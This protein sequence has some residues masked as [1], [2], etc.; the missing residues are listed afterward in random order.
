LNY[1]LNFSTNFLCMQSLYDPLLPGIEG[2]VFMDW[3]FSSLII[4]TRHLVS[5]EVFGSVIPM[6]LGGLH[7]SYGRV[8]YQS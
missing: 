3:K 4:I 6:I 5:P 7:H 1:W 2:W 8:I